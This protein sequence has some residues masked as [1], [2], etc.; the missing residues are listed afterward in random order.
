MMELEEETL[1]PTGVGVRER[2]EV[3]MREGVV[4]AWCEFLVGIGK[5]EGLRN[6]EV[7]GRITRCEFV[8]SSC[9]PY[10][11]L[12]PLPIP[13]TVL[14]ELRLWWCPQ[15]V[16]ISIHNSGYYFVQDRRCLVRAYDV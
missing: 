10:L 2:P 1:R 11:F 13:F 9:C 7:F 14:P 6:R 15:D 12:S 5:T 4:C 8:P 3:E 16:G